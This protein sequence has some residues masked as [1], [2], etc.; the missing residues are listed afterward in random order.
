VESAG[1]LYL[2][3]CACENIIPTCTAPPTPRPLHST[4]APLPH[5]PRPR[6]RSYPN[7]Y[8]TSANSIEALVN[9][10]AVSGNR[11]YGAS[12]E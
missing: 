6:C 4:T 9:Y 5:A 10:M 3:P 2:H 11:T 7:D 12:V 8:W 1:L